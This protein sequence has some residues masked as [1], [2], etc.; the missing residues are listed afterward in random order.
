MITLTGILRQAGEVKIKEKPL[1]KIVVEHETARDSGVPDLHLETLF[2]DRQE[3][4]RLP[5]TG[6]EVHV[7]VRPYPT[8]NGRGVAFSAV[9]LLTAADPADP[10]AV[11]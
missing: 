5:R 10:L 6:E 11:A 4:A 9:R 8:A 3:A 1:L 7:E 2:V